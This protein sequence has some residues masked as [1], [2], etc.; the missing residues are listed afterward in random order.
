[1][2][3]REQIHRQITTLTLIRGTPF[4]PVALSQVH[5]CAHAARN[6]HKVA[7]PSIPR[8]ALPCYL[9]LILDLL[10]ATAFSSSNRLRSSARGRVS[11]SYSLGR[12]FTA[13]GSSR[14]G[15]SG[16]T[17]ILGSASSSWADPNHRTTST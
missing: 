3:Y 7:P 16:L 1:M 12:R 15:R 11:R 2:P 10:Y 4:L 13:R 17:T 9:C 6:G 8:V 14:S 5:A